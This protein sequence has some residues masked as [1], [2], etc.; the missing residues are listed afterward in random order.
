L[1]VQP[2]VEPAEIWYI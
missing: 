2:A 1:F